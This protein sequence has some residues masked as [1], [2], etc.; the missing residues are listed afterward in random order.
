MIPPQELS[1]G[2]KL[3]VP[4]EVNLRAKLEFEPFVHS[5]PAVVA[6]ESIIG[7]R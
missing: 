5:W 2:H 1:K 4:V 3:K 6:V 7:C